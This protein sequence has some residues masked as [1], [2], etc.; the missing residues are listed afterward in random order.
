[1]FH[2]LINFCK[3]REDVYIY[4]CVV[5]EMFLIFIMLHPIAKWIERDNKAPRRD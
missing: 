2:L 1:M 3:F 5:T 4:L